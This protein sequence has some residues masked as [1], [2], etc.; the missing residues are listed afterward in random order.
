LAYLWA[1]PY[2]A[3]QGHLVGVL[4]YHRPPYPGFLPRVQGLL[5]TRTPAPLAG[6]EGL[7]SLAV[8]GVD[9]PLHGLR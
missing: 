8:K 5:L 3:G 7:V 6:C 2:Q 1:G 9:P 4:A